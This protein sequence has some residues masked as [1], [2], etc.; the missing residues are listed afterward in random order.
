MRRTIFSE[1]VIFLFLILIQSFANSQFVYNGFGNASLENDGAARV[2]ENGLLQLTGH[3]D[4]YEQGHAFYF[5]SLKLKGN[6]SFSTTFVIG[7]VSPLDEISGQGMAF[8][9]APQRSLPGAF[10]H[11]FLGLFNDTNNG[12]STNHVFAVE[13]DTISNVE[14]DTVG[15]P[16][17]GIDINSLNSV[18]STSPGYFI[19][20][21]YKELS[22][23]KEPVQV[24][25]EYDGKD[26]KIEV[27]LAP[28]NV[29]KPDVALL[30]YT[31]DLSAIF[32]KHM[33]VGFSASTESVLTSHYVLGWSFKI[34]NKSPALNF[35]SL[36]M[37]PPPPPPS[38]SPSLSPSPSPSSSPPL[39]PSNN[40]K[41]LIIALPVV[42]SIIILGLLVFLGLYYSRKTNTNNIAVPAPPVPGIR[43]FSYSDLEEAT[44][45]FSEQIGKGALG[46]V[47][48][49]VLPNSEMQVAVTKVSRDAKYKPQQFMAEIE[50][51]GKLCHRNLVHLHGY[52]EHEGQLLLVYEFMPNGS[53]DMFLYPKQNPLYCTLN[54]SQ[55]FQ[56]IKDVAN[57]LF[58]L[59]KGWEQV[60]IHRDIKSSNV[61][62]DDQMNA[63]LMGD[64]GLAKLYDNGAD[65]API[66]RVVGTPGYNA[67]EVR[68]GTP[69]TQT[70]VY[71]LGA[72]LLEIACGRR[73]NL[74]AER[75]L[76]LVDWVL[77]CMKGNTLLNTADKRLEGD[78]AEEEMLLVLKL[79]LLC[80]RFDP[81]ARPTIQ[82]IVQFLSGDASEADLRALHKTDE[83]PVRYGGGGNTSPLSGIRVGSASSSDD[84]ILSRQS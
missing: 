75:D 69:S 66:P 82:K 78:Y 64:F 37:L 59:H 57:G 80:C 72:L 34:D 44:N 9:I 42:G 70:D 8:V 21:E 76:H 53:L 81:T 61:L 74:V 26:K 68:Y 32:K 30:T 43:K 5:E 13:L 50:S 12:N 3:K 56:I 6:V 29:S 16:H 33:Y 15:G 73:P 40:K 36:P 45:V 28:W 1:I 67:P 49:G 51:L 25:V 46:T 71:A 38:P 84:P 24:W 18:N 41:I 11:Q 52:C 60:V 77:S 58:Y 47:Y 35:S 55:R 27:T 63:R 48:R 54:W 14:F 7:I 4:I 39:K 20:G 83:A 79:G 23:D 10:T 62:L 19:N 65:N 31:Q 2:T 17:V 22:L